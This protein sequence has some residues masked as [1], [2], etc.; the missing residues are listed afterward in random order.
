MAKE[1]IIAEFPE[2]KLCGSKE[3]L[4]QKAWKYVYPDDKEM[5]F[6]GMPTV[7]IPLTAHSAAVN[8][9]LPAVPGLAIFE[10]YCAG[11]GLKRATKAIKTIVPAALLQQALAQMMGQKPKR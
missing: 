1:E 11:C 5:P 3:T 10:D 6:T 4:T 8:I 7:M 9:S 2:C